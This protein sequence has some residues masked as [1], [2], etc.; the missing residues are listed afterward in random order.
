MHIRLAHM[1]CL[2]CI[3]TLRGASY[4]P[5]VSSC[6][7]IFPALALLQKLCSGQIISTGFE[8]GRPA[9]LTAKGV[10]SRSYLDGIRNESDVP[11]NL[12]MPGPA[13]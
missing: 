6:K 8:Y 10:V 1:I 12:L 5:V 13:I 9:G 3:R 2:D 7:P 11:A 4:C